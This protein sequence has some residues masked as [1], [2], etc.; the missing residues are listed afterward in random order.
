MKKSLTQDNRVISGR[1]KMSMNCFMLWLWELWKGHLLCVLYGFADAQTN[2][3]SVRGVG[4]NHLAIE[5]TH[6]L[7]RNVTTFVH[8][9]DLLVRNW[10]KAPVTETHICGPFST[11]F[12]HLWCVQGNENDTDERTSQKKKSIWLEL[13]WFFRPVGVGFELL[14]QILVSLT[15]VVANLFQFF[16][17]MFSFHFD[18]LYQQDVFSQRTVA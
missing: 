13:L 14:E 4:A 6:D 2:K 1:E 12:L 7:Q 16:F 10:M 9:Y 11:R 3:C 18:V 8:G 5:V 15:A 17:F